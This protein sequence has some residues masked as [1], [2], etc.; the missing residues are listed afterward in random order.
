MEPVPVLANITLREAARCLPCMQALARSTMT[1]LAMIWT[2]TA[3]V[4][5]L[6][7]EGQSTHGVA[8]CGSCD[9]ETIGDRLWL[10]SHPAGAYGNLFDGAPCNGWRSRISPVEAAVSCVASCCGC[11][12][13]CYGCGLLLRLCD[14]LLQLRDLVLQLCDRRPWRWR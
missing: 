12:A 4:A 3:A 7:A 10:W 11:V 2:V 6:Q 8:R 14:V 13:S 5:I 9:G 1:P